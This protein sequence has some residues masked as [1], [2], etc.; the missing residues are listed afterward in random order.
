MECLGFEL[1]DITMDFKKGYMQVGC[2]YKKVPTPRDPATC[3]NFLDV[4]RNGPNEAMKMAQKMMENPDEA[5]AFAKS[6]VDGEKEEQVDLDS[7]ESSG[8]KKVTHDEL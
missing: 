5:Q 7:H 4:L 1:S 8:D 6:L 3:E 2:G